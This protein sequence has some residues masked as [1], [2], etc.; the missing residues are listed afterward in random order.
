MQCNPSLT[1]AGC[2][3][4]LNHTSLTL[5]PK[6]PNPSK[7]NDFRPISCC[8]LVYKCIS[9]IIAT[10]C[11]RPIFFALLKKRVV[12]GPDFKYHWRCSRTA[13]TH[14]SFADDLILF[15]GDM[16]KSAQ[17]L[18]KAL[19]DFLSLSGLYLNSSKSTI[20][21][22]GRNTRLGEAVQRIFGFLFGSLLIRYLGIPLI[23]SKLTYSDCLPLVDHS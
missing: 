2:L 9:S 5:V 7:M 6:G 12:D 19:I 4:K 16:P 15:C 10:W 22:I 8:N 11:T 23:Y 17:V 20:F 21:V 18:H 1:R 13:T 3:K 14:L